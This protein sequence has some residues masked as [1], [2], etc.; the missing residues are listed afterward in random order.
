METIKPRFNYTQGAWQG[1]NYEKTRDMT[2]SELTK[3]IRNGLKEMFAGCTFSVTKQ[4]Y[5]GG[6]S[7]D[8][9][10]MSATFKVFAT[11][12]LEVAESN[13][14]H[15]YTAEEIM[16]MWQDAITKG[17][18][19]LNPHNISEDFY[20]TDKAREVLTRALGFV[21]SFNFDDSDSQSDYFHTNFY[22]HPSIGRWSKP[23]VQK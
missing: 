10:L 9:V 17:H 4:D 5:S 22:L 2:T 11:P 14:R 6:R 7:I 18:H 23:F 15:N 1:S 20:L 19:G 13:R 8:V 21:Q 3:A 12:S 16:A